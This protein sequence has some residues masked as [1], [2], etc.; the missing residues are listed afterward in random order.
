M[1]ELDQASEISCSPLDGCW[2]YRATCKQ[3]YQVIAALVHP[4]F[5]GLSI[6]IG[7]RKE[8]EEMQHGQTDCF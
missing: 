1:A 4:I 7:Q 6:Q 5:L 8:T 3:M 2:V